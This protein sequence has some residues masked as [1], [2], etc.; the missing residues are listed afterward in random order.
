L[1]DGLLG[2]NNDFS[3]QSS[4]EVMIDEYPNLFYS[5]NKE[6]LRPVGN[7]EQFYRKID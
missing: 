3:Q 1:F 7:D 5:M 2:Q 4:G 6:I